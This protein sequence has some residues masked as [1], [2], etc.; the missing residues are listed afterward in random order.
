MPNESWTRCRVGSGTLASR[1]VE[2]T[3]NNVN[4]QSQTLLWT[5]RLRRH[6]PPFHPLRPPLLPTIRAG[7]LA[8]RAREDRLEREEEGDVA[9]EE[10]GRL[11]APTDQ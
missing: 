9:E 3:G 6:R 5:R 1:P 4:P 8:E 7:G 2:A 10:E 11:G